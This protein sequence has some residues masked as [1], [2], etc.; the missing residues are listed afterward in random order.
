MKLNKVQLGVLVTIILIIVERY[1]FY[2]YLNFDSLYRESMVN[3]GLTESQV[4]DTFSYQSWIIPIVFLVQ[5]LGVFFTAAFLYMGVKLL[6]YKVS[7]K[8]LVGI[9]FIAY[10]LIVIGKL[11][12]FIWLKLNIEKVTEYDFLKDFKSLSLQNL[13]NYNAINYSTFKVFGEINLFRVL[14]WVFLTFLL[15]RV[16]KVKFWKSFEVVLYFNI[17]LFFLIN[18]TKLLLTLNFDS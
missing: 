4:D 10:S 1:L 16:L 6:N 7:F 18:L 11:V 13:Y 3:E 2:S 12:D 14:F 5:L 15:S 8:K 9:N 17:T